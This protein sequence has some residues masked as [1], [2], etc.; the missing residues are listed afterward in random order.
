MKRVFSLLL[1]FA[2]ALTLA[3]SAGAEQ[4]SSFL[5]PLIWSDETVLYLV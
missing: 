4:Q 3:L 5:Y 2:L 1:C